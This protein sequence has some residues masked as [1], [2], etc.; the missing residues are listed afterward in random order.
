MAVQAK[1]A[2]ENISEQFYKQNGVVQTSGKQ[3]RLRAVYSNDPAS[4]N[5]SF[6]QATPTANLEMYINNPEA[7]DYFEG[8]AEY[9]LTFEKV[10]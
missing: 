7:F 3:V 2:V 6:S 5:Y 8:G 4:P 10:A 1:L 9:L